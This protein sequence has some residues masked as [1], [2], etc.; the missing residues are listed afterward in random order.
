MKNRARP[1][2]AALALTASVI[3]V[4]AVAGPAAGDPTSA[5]AFA[6]GD[7][8]AAVLNSPV[9]FWGSQWR[10]DNQLSTGTA[11]ASFKGY[12]VNV[13]SATCTFT[14]TTGNSAPPPSGPLPPVITVLVTSAVTQSGSTISG[15]ITEFALVATNAGYDSNPGHAGTGTVRDTYPCVAVGGD[16]GGNGGVN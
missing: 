1:L 3:A 14:T 15:K 5:G 6:I 9:T 2:L 4:A 13:D 7:V 11:P 12:A 16:G 10:K 8:N